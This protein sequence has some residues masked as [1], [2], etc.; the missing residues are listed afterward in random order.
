MRVIRAFLNVAIATAATL[1][2]AG[3]ASAQQELSEDREVVERE[4]RP[5]TM[6]E[7]I[8]KRLEAIHELIGNNENAEALARGTALLE[9]SRMN[10]YERA[11]VLQAVGFVHA[12]E[13][14][15][16]QAI[17]YF[18][19]SLALDALPT[20]AQQGMLYS[21]AG[22]YA[23]QE[24][25]MKSIETARQWFKYEPD[26]KAE[27]YMLIGSAFSQLERYE[28]ALPYV[29]R[30]IEKKDSPPESW[31]QLQMAIYFE[32]K[33][34][35]KAVPLL[36][37]MIQLWPDKQQYW[38]TLSGAHM[39]LGQD[40]DALSTMMVAYR[41]G[42]TTEE[43]KILSLVRLNMFLEIPYTAGQILSEELAAGR[44]ARTKEHLNLLE[45]AWTAAQEYDKALEV[46]GE[47]GEM[48]GDPEYAIR[49]AKV[50]NELT[51]WEDV[52][53]AADRALEQ[54]YDDKGEAYLL[55]GTAYSELGRLRDS[56]AAFK[57]A[58]NTGDADQRRNARAWIGFVNDRLKIAS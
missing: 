47:L 51:R 55:I 53:A 1:A 6:S 40:R 22:L 36:Q 14:R 8:Y 43:K 26:P 25:Y 16:P 31:Y 33:Q 38:E 37:K 23:A 57:Q 5:Q 3:S 44:V 24:Q 18:E 45:Q 48:T 13:S 46:M 9:K 21:L 39:E 4:Q 34:I 2:I 27:A 54:G 30:A 12:N 32:T 11:L 19:K 17:D 35:A 28:D 7:A 50:Y 42:L 10:D 56:L 52:I 29:V 20:Q 49:Q 58:E 15:F 41:K